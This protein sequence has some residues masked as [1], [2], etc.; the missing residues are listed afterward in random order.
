MSR[1]N[2][3]LLRNGGSGCGPG[4]ITAWQRPAPTGRN[5][6]AKNTEPR[7]AVWSFVKA[8]AGN[9]R[10]HEETRTGCS[11][12]VGGSSHDRLLLGRKSFAK[13]GPI[14]SNDRRR[15]LREVAQR[16]HDDDRGRDFVSSAT[17]FRWWERSMSGAGVGRKRPAQLTSSCP[18][19]A[20]EP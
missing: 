7:T 2:G 5:E 18:W 6:S 12:C 19:R 9:A 10:I 14:T 15:Q 1:A 11:D 16:H 13:R 20:W 17:V 4:L 8:D 3:D